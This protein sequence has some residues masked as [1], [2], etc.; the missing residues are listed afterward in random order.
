MRET[1]VVTGANGFIGRHLCS[2]LMRAGVA[3][4]GVVRRPE[5]L[6]ELPPGVEPVVVGTMTDVAAWDEVVTG[7][8]AVV[9]LIGRAHVMRD[10]APDRLTAYRAVNVGVTQAL[11]AACLSKGVRHLV[12]L[13]SIKAVGEG[14]SAPYHEDS[15]CTPEDAYGVSKREAEELVLAAGQGG[16]VTTV[17]RP[18]LVY[19]PGVKGNFL[20]LLGI[21]YR[22]LPIPLGSVKNARSMVFVGNLTRAIQAILNSPL[23]AMGVLHVTDP[24]QPLSTAELVRRLAQLMGRPARLV[25]FPVGLM[26]LGGKFLGRSEDVDRVTR[27]LV[28]SADRIRE[29]LGWEP[30][31]SVDEGLAQTVEWYLGER[32][33]HLDK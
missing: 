18:P 32:G 23:E 7:V 31:Y 6:G 26:R 28:V 12:Y 21:A 4:R 16:F 3:V 22:G 11:V 13:S 25:P 29:R 24:G 19:G 17:V 30:P 5:A 14:G 33:G 27:S 10:P 8:P 15:P 20:R 9:H 1:V 2:E